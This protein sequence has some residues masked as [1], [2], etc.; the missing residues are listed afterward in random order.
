MN[1]E[2]EQTEDE[3]WADVIGATVACAIVVMLVVVLAVML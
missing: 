3:P 2:F 1:D